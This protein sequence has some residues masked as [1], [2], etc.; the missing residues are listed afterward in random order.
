MCISIDIY[1]NI[2][3]YVDVYVVISMERLDSCI[4]QARKTEVE[5]YEGT[6]VDYKDNREDRIEK[7]IGERR[8]K[9]PMA[10]D[11]ERRQE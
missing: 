11:K 5:R 8:I 1:V 6:V 9:E 2:H 4:S 10:I 7:E 3:I